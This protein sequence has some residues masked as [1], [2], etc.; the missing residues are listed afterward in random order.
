MGTAGHSSGRAE[1]TQAIVESQPAVRFPGSVGQRRAFVV[2]DNADPGSK[3]TAA[4]SVY[5]R[6]VAVVAGQALELAAALE[7]YGL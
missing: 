7:L 3:G 5:H 6:H 1:S 2:P 4:V